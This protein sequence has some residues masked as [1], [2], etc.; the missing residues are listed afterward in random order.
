MSLRARI[1]LN[2]RRRRNLGIAAGIRHRG[3][4]NPLHWNNAR[5]SWRRVILVLV[6]REAGAHFGRC[7]NKRNGKDHRALQFLLSR[8]A[9]RR[10]AAAKDV[11]HKV[12]HGGKFCSL[13][14]DNFRFAHDH[15]GAVIDRMARRAGRADDAIEQCYVQAERRAAHQRLH[16]AARGRAVQK[17]FVAHPYIVGWH[18][19]WHAIVD[20]RHLANECLIQ[21]AINQFAVVTSAIRLAADFGS[22]G[23]SKVAHARRLAVVGALPQAPIWTPGIDVIRE[24]CRL[25]SALPRRKQ[26]GGRTWRSPQLFL[27]VRRFDSSKT[28]AAIT[29]RLGWIKTASATSPALFSHFAACL[30]SFPL[31]FSTWTRASTFPVGPVRPFRA[32]IATFASRETRRRTKH[33]CI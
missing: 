3:L 17:Q 9:H 19:D 21:D 11:L 4:R 6:D 10:P 23:G 14:V 30:K 12:A 28:S 5:P 1:V 29:V 13:A 33:R 31:M 24:S 8:G 7:L 26:G 15:H 22:F 32:S 16:Q 2:V 27:L 25:W 20:E 18:N